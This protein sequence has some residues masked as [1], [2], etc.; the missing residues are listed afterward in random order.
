[1]YWFLFYGHRIFYSYYQIFIDILIFSI[2]IYMFYFTF[3]LLLFL[4]LFVILSFL[5]V[6]TSL[7]MVCL[8]SF[9]FLV[10]YTFLS[11]FLLSFL[12]LYNTITLLICQYFSWNKFNYSV[13]FIQNHKLTFFL[14]ASTTNLPVIRNQVCLVHPSFLHYRNASLK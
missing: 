2:T 7:S 13:N 11:F 14:I 9:K 5:V 12:C 3:Y 6:R 4:L 10:V 8:H 1:M